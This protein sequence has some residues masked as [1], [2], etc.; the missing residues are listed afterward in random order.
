MFLLKTLSHKAILVSICK[1]WE[2]PLAYF[3]D[4]DWRVFLLLSVGASLSPCPHYARVLHPP[5]LACI[6]PAQMLVWSLSE[7]ILTFLA[8]LCLAG[9]VPL[10][11]LPNSHTCT[12]R[13]SEVYGGGAN[14]LSQLKYHR[15]NVLS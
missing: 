7:K 14:C 6:V 10:G 5:P 3:C 2:V 4:I 11:N 13:G 1:G 12:K 8:R 9:S 15:L